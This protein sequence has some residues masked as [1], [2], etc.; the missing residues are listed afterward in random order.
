[1]TQAKKFES[2]GVPREQ[3]EDL[4]TYLT[5]QIILDR[6]RLSEKFTAKVELEK[7]CVKAWLPSDPGLVLQRH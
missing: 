1:M 7:V 3:A 2:L 6:L 4:S 5:Q